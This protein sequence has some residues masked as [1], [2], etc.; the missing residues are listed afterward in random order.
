MTTLRMIGSHSN[1][2]YLAQERLS[3]PLNSSLHSYV[4]YISLR[5]IHPILAISF[6]LP[7]IHVPLPFIHILTCF[8]DYPTTKIPEIPSPRLR[9][10]TSPDY[11][12]IVAE[13]TLRLTLDI[14]GIYKGSKLIVTN[15]DSKPTQR[16][17]FHNGYIESA[18]SGMVLTVEVGSNLQPKVV[19]NPGI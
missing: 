11:F 7:T 1:I 2:S 8:L 5:K 3:T 6:T 4:D 15:C 16:F 13:H 17:Y 12:Y 9:R 10:I 18:K 14:S 19:L